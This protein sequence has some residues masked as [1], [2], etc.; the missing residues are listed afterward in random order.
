MAILWLSEFVAILIRVLFDSHID[1]LLKFEEIAASLL[2]NPLHSSYESCTHRNASFYFKI[3]P[4]ISLSPLA[5]LASNILK[6]ATNFSIVNCQAAEIVVFFALDDCFQSFN[7]HSERRFEDTRS[8]KISTSSFLKSHFNTSLI[9]AL[10]TT[11]STNCIKQLIDLRL[12]FY[13]ASFMIER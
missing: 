9:F 3:F 1:R 8:I 12:G 13:V 7:L 10:L 5:D 4:R 11:S 2:V 6:T